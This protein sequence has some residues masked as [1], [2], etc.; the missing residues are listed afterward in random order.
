MNY[1]DLKKIVSTGEDSTRQFKIDITNADSLAAEIAAFSNSNG[2]T[3]YIGIHDSR[4]ISG[5]DPKELNRLNQLISNTASQNVRSPV[6]VHTEN[7]SLP[8]G[9][10]VLILKIPAGID[11]PYFDKNG[12][13]WLK[14]G[15]DKRR[16][17]SKEELR[18]LFQ[19]S[20]QIHADEVPTTAGMAQLDKISF[21]DFLRERFDMKL[22]ETDARLSKL[23]ENM[24]LAKDAHLNLA[25]LLLFGERPQFIKPSFIVKAVSYPGKGVDTDK[26]L[27]SE[28]FE[29]TLK[30]MFA[31]SLSF[32]MRNLVKVQKKKGI[33]STGIP[34]IPRIVFEEILVNALGH[35]DYFI[36]APIRI[37]I[38]SDR[39]EILSPGNLPDNLTVEKILKGNSNIRNPI[40]ASFISKGILPYRG[41]GTGIRRA[42]ENWPE[43]VFSDDRDACVFKSVINRLKVHNAPIKGVVEPINAPINEPIKNIRE[44]V[45]LRIRLSPDISYNQIAHDLKIGRSTV[46]RH[47]RELKACKIIKR[48]GSKKKGRWEI[49]GKLTA[50][51]NSK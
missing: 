17:N 44:A 45:I 10:L 25:G 46:M 27:D 50:I 3:I 30:S 40:L 5:I 26:Y 19:S 34:E 14:T 16:I 8:N 31:G 33:N 28:D 22:P 23:L 42:I 20:D 4:C 48:I 29:G 24:N 1:H 32:I 13:I 2:G 6:T 11:K 36:S 21:R 7:V 18:R 37:F 49:V 35:R 39:V 9:K 41:L 51:D 15:A 47:I 43:I 12:V 38:F